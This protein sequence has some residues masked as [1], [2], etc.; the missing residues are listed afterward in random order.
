MAVSK[1]TQG[2]MWWFCHYLCCRIT[3]CFKF[4]RPKAQPCWLLCWWRAEKSRSAHDLIYIH[5]CH[6]RHVDL[7]YHVTWTKCLMQNGSTRRHV[8]MNFGHLFFN[9]LN[10][11]NEKSAEKLLW[12]H[13]GFLV[14]FLPCPGPICGLSSFGVPVTGTSPLKMSVLCPIGRTDL[15]KKRIF[16]MSRC[17]VSIKVVRWIHKRWFNCLGQ[18]YL[19]TPLQNS[20]TCHC[21]SEAY[22]CCLY[23]FPWVACGWSVHA[24]HTLRV[25]LHCEKKEENFFFTSVLAEN[26]ENI[27]LYIWE[28]FVII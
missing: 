26:M 18:P 4:E 16:S 25:L 7:V 2:F 8:F 14:V 27:S 1:E 21:W 24:S 28:F 19:N 10:K 20:I 12:V 3:F 9:F 11:F 15:T 22:Q 6:I 5:F 17:F 13:C 23:G